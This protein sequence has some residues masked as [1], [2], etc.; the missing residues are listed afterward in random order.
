MHRILIVTTDNEPGVLDR[1]ASTF[2]RRGFNIHSLTVSPTM[3]PA[4]SR[5][6]L[7]TGRSPRNPRAFLERLLNVHSVVDLSEVPSL[8]RDTAM[9]RVTATAANRAELFQLAQIFQAEVLDVSPGSLVMAVCASPERVD[10]LLES[11]RPYGLLE[12]GRSGA[13]A[14][15]R[16]SNI[17]AL[18]VDAESIPDAVDF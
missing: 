8:V 18:P 1:V 7:V 2:R 15:Q 11:L 9:L 4:V 14:M 16:K 3:D 12:L 13:V 10:A 5:M 17:E 6:T